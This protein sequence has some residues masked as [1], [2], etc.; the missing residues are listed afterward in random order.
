MWTLSKG[1][2]MW[3]QEQNGKIKYTERYK[4]NGK[5]K[6]VSI[7]YP[8]DTAHNRKEASEKL[9]ERIKMILEAPEM[10]K[11]I[12]EVFKA[13]CKY[14]Q[15]HTRP[16]TQRRN[17]YVLEAVLEKLGDVQ[18]NAITAGYIKEHL[19]DDEP[20]KY[21]QRLVRLKAFLRWAYENDY[22]DSVDFL[23][24]LKP[25]ETQAKEKLKDK[26]LEKKEL[27]RLVDG[28]AVEK[29]RLVTLF[30]ALTGMRIGELMALNITDVK[31]KTIR[32]NKTFLI[33]HGKAGKVQHLTKT[34]ASTRD[35]YIQSELKP[36]IYQIR[37]LERTDAR[38]ISFKYD[39]YRKYL[40]ENSERILH[41]KITPHIF[42]HTM[43][44]LM[45]AEGV[46]LEVISRR[47]GHSDSDVTRQVYFHV[48]D[49]LKNRDAMLI[50][51]AKLL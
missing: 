36:I 49:G 39:A 44:S 7:T 18:M 12:A 2:P 20:D 41:R 40:R 32:I 50:E 8:K 5:Y 28:M 14:Q 15:K 46:P 43:T 37:Q 47:L 34:D 22:I 16:A 33:G 3:P 19:P 38:F 25:L 45:A 10:G 29:W 4:V 35:I 30:L 42:R 51:K 13:Y 48:T 23:A 1:M 11:P 17:K 21:N 27:K 31:I 6:T 26:Y 24:K 9:N